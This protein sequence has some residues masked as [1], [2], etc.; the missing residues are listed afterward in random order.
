MHP[1][2]GQSAIFVMPSGQ[3]M[4][5]HGCASARAQRTKN[6]G[7]SF[8]RVRFMRRLYHFVIAMWSAKEAES[9]AYEKD[10]SP[11]KIFDEPVACAA[12]VHAH[13]TCVRLL[14]V[15]AASASRLPRCLLNELQHRPR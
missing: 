11:I 5:G 13:S 1:S 7:K 2:S 6:K 8:I 15:F 4:S 9:R 3:G 12:C 14:Y 10:N